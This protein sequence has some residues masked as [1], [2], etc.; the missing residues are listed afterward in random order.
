[1]EKLHQPI[2]ATKKKNPVPTKR[3]LFISNKPAFGFFKIPRN[4]KIKY[5]TSSNPFNIKEIGRLITTE[6]E[7]MNI[8]LNII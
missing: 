4:E 8:R 5:T 7:R 2:S 1:M 6:M 3:R